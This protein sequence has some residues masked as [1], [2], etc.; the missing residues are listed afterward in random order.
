M[1]CALRLLGRRD[2]SSQELALK[3]AQRGFEPT[4]IEVVLSECRRLQYLDDGAYGRNY[5]Q[6]LRHKGYGLRRIE[7]TLFAK[8]LAPELIRLTTQSCCASEQQLADC[9]QALIKWLRA[10]R[11][12]Y[13]ADVKAASYRF[14]LS[15]GFA[16]D[17]IQQALAQT[18]E[19]E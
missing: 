4:E 19:E 10:G 13:C 3:L 5:A 7:Q 12:R 17:I 11:R 2:H 15:R 18:V 1:Q 9:R 16:A 14:L 6:Q 8:H